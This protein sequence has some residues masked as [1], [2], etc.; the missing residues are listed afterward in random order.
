[1]SGTRIYARRT[2]GDERPAVYWGEI[3]GSNVGRLCVHRY[4]WAARV[5]AWWR[6]RSA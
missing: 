4:M 3:D 6:R 5:C 1:M 2:P